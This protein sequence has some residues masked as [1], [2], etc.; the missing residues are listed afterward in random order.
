MANQEQMEALRDQLRRLVEEG[1]LERAV[2]LLAEEHPADQADLIYELENEDAEH[3]IRALPADHLAEVLEFLDEDL[4]AEALADLPANVI[5]PVL[6]QLDEDVAADIVQDLEPEHAGEIVQLLEDRESVQE[7]LSYPEESAGGR[8]STEVVALRRTWTVEEAI[9]FLRR[10]SPDDHHPF[11]LY[12]VDEEHRLIGTVSL[13][14]LVTAAPETPIAAIMSDQALLSVRVDEDQE[15]AAERMRHYNLLAL[16]V[17]DASGSLRG[18][19]TADDVLDVQQEEATEDMY[20]LA[21][22][23]EEERIFRPIRDAV[24]PRLAW[25]S[26]NLITAFLAAATVSVFEGTIERVAALA[27]FMPMIAGMGGNAG[28]QTI[29]LVVRSIALGEIETRDAMEV[30]RHEVIIALIKGVFIGIIVGAIAF[31]WMGNYWFG[32]I[33]G[34]AML[35]NIVNATLVGVM[36]PLALKRLRA[37]PALASGVIVTTFSDVVGFLV[38]LGLGALLVTKLT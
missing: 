20:R 23:P 4:R 11:Y 30:L 31:A 29:T 18:V 6:D 19:I 2:A 10:E 36:V 7:L 15:V 27:V 12:V 16:P 35:A 28:I 34:V 8:M 38:F 14:A 33:V 13:R 1:S 24:P 9:Q 25:L 37:D 17:V 3:L 22:L 32:I 5:A 21:G 26:L